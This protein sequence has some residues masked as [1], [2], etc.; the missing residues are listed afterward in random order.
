MIPESIWIEKTTLNDNF[1]NDSIINSH[2]V[3]FM[4]RPNTEKENLQELI[5][6][7]YSGT[8]ANSKKRVF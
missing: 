7:M 5:T 4:E 2:P 8:D 3:Y 1:T 6:L